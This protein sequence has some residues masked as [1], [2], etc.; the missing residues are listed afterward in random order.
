MLIICRLSVGI[1][2]EADPDNTAM[3]FMMEKAVK[4]QKIFLDAGNL[5]FFVFVI[6]MMAEAR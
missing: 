6:R 4:A 2:S 1:N 5:V 3:A